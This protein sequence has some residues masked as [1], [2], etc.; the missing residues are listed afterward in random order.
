MT[1]ETGRAHKFSEIYRLH[2]WSGISKSGPGSDKANISEYCNYV[3]KVLTELKGRG[4][5]TIAEIGCGDWSV[6]EKLELAQFKSYLGIDIVPDIIEA[7]KEKFGRGSV[8][9]KCLDVV[10]EDLPFS[11]IVIAKDVLQ[12]LSNS[13]V[14]TVVNRLREA[15]N[16]LIV[17]N[18]VKKEC[19][20]KT[21]KLFKMWKMI[22]DRGF[23]NQDIEDGSSRPID[24]KADPFNL[25]PETSY[26]YYSYLEKNSCIERY[27]KE[28]LLL[29]FPKAE[30]R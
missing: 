18:D 6:T 2:S 3:N 19:A 12:H 21:F 8:A 4:A 30:E 1:Y 16:H 11:D 26:R 23:L 20:I 24:L 5:Q 14:L 28:I 10:D 22:Y 17:T 9:F 29:N 25:Q 15:C 27:T 7:N 13:S